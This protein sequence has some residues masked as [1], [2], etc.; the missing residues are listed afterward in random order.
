MRDSLRNTRAALLAAAALALLP[1]AASAQQAPVQQAAQRLDAATVVGTSKTSA[2]TITITPTAGLS[3]YMTGVDIENCGNA[4]GA[5]AA[6]PTDITSTNMNG[7]VWT[8]G[9]GAGAGLCQPFTAMYATPLKAAAPGVA[10][11]VLPTFATNQIV[12][13]SVY[14]YFAN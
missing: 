2:A 8:I 6:A 10:T 3:F 5:T 14:G 12:R 7:A 11:F 4:T 13:F 1:V 9:S